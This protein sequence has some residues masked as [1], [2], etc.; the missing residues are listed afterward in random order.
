MCWEYTIFELLS[1]SYITF[2]DEYMKD[3]AEAMQDIA[4]QPEVNE[5]NAS[6][7]K[8]KKLMGNILKCYGLFVVLFW[9]LSPEI[10]TTYFPPVG[11]ASF[12][13]PCLVSVIYFFRIVYCL[14][15][16]NWESFNFSILIF[17]MG[18]II[19][20]G[21]CYGNLTFLG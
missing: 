8:E 2:C 10:N 6:L 5:E 13:L 16:K 17:F 15:Q 19:G 11:I 12:S 9:V 7:T 20:A 3:F 4:Q 21:V 1:L 18:L 14:F